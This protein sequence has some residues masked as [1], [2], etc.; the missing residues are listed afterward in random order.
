VL[1]LLNLKFPINS[2]KEKQKIAIFKNFM[3]A[4]LLTKPIFLAVE[5]MRFMETKNSNLYDK[6]RWNHNVRNDFFLQMAAILDTEVQ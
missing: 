6:K 1:N 4:F 5:S 3:R 2:V